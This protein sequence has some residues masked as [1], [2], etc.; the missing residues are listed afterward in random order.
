MRPNT[1]VKNLNLKS[2]LSQINGIIRDKLN[3]RLDDTSDSDCKHQANLRW[4]P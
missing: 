4:K 3:G 2:K 1:I